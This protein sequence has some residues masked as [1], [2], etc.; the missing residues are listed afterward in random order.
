MQTINNGAHYYVEAMSSPSM[1]LNAGLLHHHLG[2]NDGQEAGT[3]L[4]QGNTKRLPHIR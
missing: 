4:F 2:G 3:F 1:Y